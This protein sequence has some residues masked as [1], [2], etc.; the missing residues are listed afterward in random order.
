MRKPFCL[1]CGEK[2]THFGRGY[3]HSLLKFN[4]G[5]IHF[6]C[7]QNY[8]DQKQQRKKIW[9]RVAPEIKQKYNRTHYLKHKEQIKIRALAYYYERQKQKEI[10]QVVV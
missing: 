5:F 3:K 1:H 7:Y 6:T 10:I 4:G 9:R 8:Q 2:I